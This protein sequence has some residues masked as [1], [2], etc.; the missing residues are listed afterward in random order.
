MERDK[1][2][3]TDKFVFTVKSN[4]SFNE[5]ERSIFVAL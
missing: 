1:L 4:D 3:S 2:K 5:K